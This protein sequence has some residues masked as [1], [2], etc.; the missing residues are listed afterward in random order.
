M[1]RNVNSSINLLPKLVDDKN[2]CSNTHDDVG[3][4]EEASFQ[5]N[6]AY[7]KTYHA[8]SITF[9]LSMICL[10]LNSI[11]PR[12]A[13]AELSIE[14]SSDAITSWTSSNVKRACKKKKKPMSQNL[15]LMMS[16][17]F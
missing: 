15:L 11:R 5:E 13:R 10:K 6:I 4:Y 17:T 2:V 7:H 3:G 1:L 14:F 8:H 16:R 9:R 12:A